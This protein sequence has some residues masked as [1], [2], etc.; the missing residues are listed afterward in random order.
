MKKWKNYICNINF[1]I[2]TLKNQD[3]KTI[4]KNPLRYGHNCWFSEK[5]ISIWNS[6]NIAISEFTFSAPNHQRAAQ[7]S[8][9]ACIYHLETYAHH[10]NIMIIEKCF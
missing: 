4:K 6:R 1:D 7:S 8:F 3:I 5:I 9:E 2:C 10:L